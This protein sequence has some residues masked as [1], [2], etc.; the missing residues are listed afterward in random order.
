MSEE[1]IKS[2]EEQIQIMSNEVRFLKAK[3]LKNDLMYELSEISD[4]EK[5]A[6]FN[7]MFK[8]AEET[9]DACT[10]D[11]FWNEDDETHSFETLFNFTIVKNKQAFW[12]YFHEEINF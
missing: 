2:L 3:K 12:N 7:M 6:K 9:I 10:K 1:R 4:E 11:C 8:Y 5:I